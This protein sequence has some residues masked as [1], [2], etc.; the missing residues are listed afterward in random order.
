MA[1]N[2]R[3]DENFGVVAALLGQE[4]KVLANGILPG[5]TPVEKSAAITGLVHGLVQRGDVDRAVEFLYGKNAIRILYDDTQIPRFNELLVEGLQRSRMDDEG[6][7]KAVDTL[8][9]QDR[10]VDALYTAALQMPNKKGME[11]LFSIEGNVEPQRWREG[12][13]SLGQRVAEQNQH[14]GYQ[15]LSAAENRG[16]VATLFDQTVESLTEGKISLAVKMLTWLKRFEYPPVQGHEENAQRRSTALMK[17]V[18]AMEPALDLWG[19]NKI[20]W[21]D[22]YSLVK[23]EGVTLEQAEQN[24]LQR[25]AL[26]EIS[27]HDLED[28]GDRLA[29]ARINYRKDPIGAYEIFVEKG[30][31]GRKFEQAIKGVFAR[32]MKDRWN[33]KGPNLPDE[34]LEIVYRDTPET[35]LKEREFIAQRLNDAAE[36]QR[37]GRIYA[38]QEGKDAQE[39]AYRL[40]VE[41]GLTFGDSLL[42]SVRSALISE[43]SRELAQNSPGFAPSFRWLDEKDRPGYE[44]AFQRLTEGEGRRTWEIGAYELAAERGD[45]ARVQQARALILERRRPEVAL[46]IFKRVEDRPGYEAAKQRLTEQ[47]PI[48][49]ESLEYLLQ[50]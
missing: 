29:W 11:I 46:G 25:F 17:K 38:A 47:Y 24:K 4:E 15:A 50:D 1:N 5:R 13:S 33:W 31:Q 39:R 16:A 41:G 14:L 20:R 49:A 34:H 3:I 43:E 10:H 30:Y 37:L 26:Q 35:S 6:R 23:Q 40:L 22:L 36:L 2:T 12:M 45:I 8:A 18:I 19:D 7:R 44:A 21:K 32:I 28:E 42:E 27:D 48:S 9:K